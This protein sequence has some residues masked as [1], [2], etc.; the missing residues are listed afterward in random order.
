M[1]PMESLENN[2]FVLVVLFVM[3]LF[4]FVVTVGNLGRSRGLRNVIKNG[5]S[6]L[7]A[8]FILGIGVCWSQYIYLAMG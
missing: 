6:K 8:F 4:R 3:L 2:I 7:I 1:T 5:V